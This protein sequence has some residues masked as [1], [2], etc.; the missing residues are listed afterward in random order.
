MVNGA[1][2]LAPPAM[3]AALVFCTVNVRSTDVPVAT[4]PKLVVVEGVTLKSGWATPLV[5]PEHGPSPPEE[6]TAVTRTK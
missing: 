4:V 6:S 1:A 2:T 3:L 5:A